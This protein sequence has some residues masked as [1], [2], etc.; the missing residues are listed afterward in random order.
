[1]PDNLKFYPE[2]RSVTIN[3]LDRQG[4]LRYF[5]E[6]FSGKISQ[7]EITLKYA[8]PA[9]LGTA[10]QALK[11][12]IRSILVNILDVTHFSVLSGRNRATIVVPICQLQD[13]SLLAHEGT[14]RVPILLKLIKHDE[15]DQELKCAQEL[16]LI[17]D[18]QEPVEED[19]LADEGDV[20]FSDQPEEK[21]GNEQD[22]L[23]YN[24]DDESLDDATGD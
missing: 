21:I 1:M 8:F 3:P 7:K 5:L 4:E 18:L 20:D 12:K 23:A 22:A 15:L 14:I 19:H 13:T 24:N 9:K 2:Q 11:D 6:G 10:S 16:H 17:T